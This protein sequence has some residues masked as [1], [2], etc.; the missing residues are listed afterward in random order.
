MAK[1][2]EINYLKAVGEEGRQ[3]AMNK[4]FS[5]ENGG[6]LLIKLG[7]IQRFFPSPPARLLDFG[8]GTGWTSW[9]LSRMGYS[10]VGQD[11]SPDMIQCANQNKFRNAAEELNFRVCDYEE[12]DYEDEFDCALFFDCLHHAVDEKLALE[13]AFRALKKG[14]ICVAHEPGTG[15]AEEEHTRREVDRYQVTEKDMPPKKI[16]SMAREIGFSTVR[17]VPF[18]DEALTALL[19]THD[20]QQVP[21]RGHGF[22]EKRKHRKRMGGLLGGVFSL[23]HRLDDSGLVVLEK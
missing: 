4:P 14:G 19:S 18:P 17:T 9:M 22:F 21:P 11:I 13:S 12:L 15:H 1:A 23:F 10:V 7:F 8:C 2:N 3:F 20:G 16:R 6:D 5:A